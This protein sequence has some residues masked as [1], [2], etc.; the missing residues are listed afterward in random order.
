MFWL[1][2]LGI[3]LILC[4]ARL[5]MILPKR[6]KEGSFKLDKSNKKLS[7]PSSIIKTLV[8]LGSGGHTGEMMDVIQTL[9]P[10]RYKLEF[11]L[12]DTD[13]TSE[14]FVR[15]LLKDKTDF[16]PLSFHYIPR[17]REVHQ[18]YFTSIF[19]TL[20]ALFYTTVITNVNINPDLV[21]FIVGCVLKFIKELLMFRLL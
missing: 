11:V 18:S 5:F 1:I 9:D 3:A 15:N 4:L 7:S 16:E 14:K 21:G 8:V 6:I 2:G 10:K 17:S 19:T 20:K 12:A 13:S